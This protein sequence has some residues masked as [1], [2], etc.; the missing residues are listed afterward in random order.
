MRRKFNKIPKLHIKQGDTVKV[1]S[2]NESIRGKTGVVLRVFPTKQRA[3]VE[4]L[5]I[6]VKHVKPTQGNAN[7]NRVEIEAPLHI[8]KLQLIEPGTGKPTRIGRKRVGNSWVRYS[9]KSGQV[10]S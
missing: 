7:G 9:K 8:S 1:L 3:L 5:N 2:G 4:G 10:I 6:V